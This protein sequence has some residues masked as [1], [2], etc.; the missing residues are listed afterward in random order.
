VSFALIE[1]ISA[2][3]LSFR[4]SG[5]PSANSLRLLCGP[6]IGVPSIFVQGSSGKAP[7]AGHLKFRALI[8][9]VCIGNH[10]AARVYAFYVLK[11]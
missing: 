1:S 5:T 10:L 7:H 8:A 6:G 4:D 2:E 11:A 3:S 9:F